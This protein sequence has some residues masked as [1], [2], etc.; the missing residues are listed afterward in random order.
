MVHSLKLNKL[1]N[2]GLALTGMEQAEAETSVRAWKQKPSEEALSENW[3]R[4][5]AGHQHLLLRDTFGITDYRNQKQP[6][7]TISS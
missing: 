7:Y 6:L 5:P 2:Q 4:Q 1:P 3:E